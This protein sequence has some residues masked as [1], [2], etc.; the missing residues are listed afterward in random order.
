MIAS[1]PEVHPTKNW[2]PAA[3]DEMR[4]AKRVFPQWRVS[5]DYYG[6]NVGFPLYSAIVFAVLTP[7]EW[8][9]RESEP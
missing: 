5:Q 7:P 1:E 2:G 9:C 4:E 8:V 3:L 6:G